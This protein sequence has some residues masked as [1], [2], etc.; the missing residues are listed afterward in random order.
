MKIENLK[1]HAS[2]GNNREDKFSTLP[3]GTAGEHSQS[4]QDNNNVCLYSSPGKRKTMISGQ[5]LIQLQLL[6][7][8][9]TG[10]KYFFD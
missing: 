10:S 2:R 4:F 6:E 7:S 1:N 5:Q 9:L 8:N 3:C